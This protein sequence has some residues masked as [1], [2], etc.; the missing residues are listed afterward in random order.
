MMMD[1]IDAARLFRQARGFVDEGLPLHAVQIYRRLVASFPSD[2]LPPTE[3]A[4][5][6]AEMGQAHA[7]VDLLSRTAAKLPGNP[8]ILFELGNALAQA[9]RHEA[10]ASVYERLR[11]ERRPEVHLRLGLT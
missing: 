5:L 3:L 6:Y 10:A 4:R 9:G 8:D 2:A 7:A 1:E 11:G